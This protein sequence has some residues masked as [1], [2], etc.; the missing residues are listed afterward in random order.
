MATRKITTLTEEDIPRPPCACGKPATCQIDINV[1]RLKLER[2]SGAH[3]ELYWRASY[4]DTVASILALVCD[5]C[6]NN[7]IKVTVT[8]A[9]SVEK[10]DFDA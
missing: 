8:A 5:N 2:D 3:S 1:R 7:N 6:Y 10:A 4:H 9:A